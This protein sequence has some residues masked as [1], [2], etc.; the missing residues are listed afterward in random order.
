[1]LCLLCLPLSSCFTGI[2]GTKK[3][4]L[5]KEDRK[6]IRPSDE[7]IFFSDVAGEPLSN[8]SKGREFVAADNKTALIF[9]QQGLPLDPESIK[10]GGKILSYEGISP[11]IAA[12][13]SRNAVIA[14][15]NGQDVFFYNTGK[16]L[17]DAPQ[18]IM[19]DQIPMIIDTHMIQ[20]AKD[21]IIGKTLWTRSP[22]WYDESGER[23]KG[24]KYVPVVI[25]DVTAGTLA[26]PL[27][28]MFEDAS[29]NRAWM[30]MNFGNSGNE[31]RSFS[32]LFS[33]SDI[34]KKYPSIDQEVWNLICNGEIR[35][36]MTKDEC[37]LSLGIPTEVSSGHDYS[38]TLD[39]WHYT[40]GKVLW[41][42]DGTLSKFR[43]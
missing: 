1:L 7:E 23:I 21:L 12:D 13:G 11:R 38:Q 2:E 15:S 8:W 6:A 41:F 29:G 4:T 39:L 30:F 37:R 20:K 9:D 22:L 31:S 10:L 16:T 19:S 33:L 40:D 28:V 17:S 32:N 3:I 27:K 36:G 42:E 14:F 34:Q 26:F 18:A 25:K 24:R 5:S 35:I 43:R